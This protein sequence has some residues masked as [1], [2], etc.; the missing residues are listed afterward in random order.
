MSPAVTI[1][2]MVALA[3]AGEAAV[4]AIDAVERAA[5]LGYGAPVLANAGHMM[6]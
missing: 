5:A 3:G 2:V 6:G 4:V 1:Y